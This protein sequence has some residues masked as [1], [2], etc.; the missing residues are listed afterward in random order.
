M[1]DIKVRN[2]NI[3]IS[4]TISIRVHVYYHYSEYHI[5]CKMCFPPN[6]T[7]QIIMV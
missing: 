6:C 5:I 1:N 7:V 2:S 4:Y 3:L